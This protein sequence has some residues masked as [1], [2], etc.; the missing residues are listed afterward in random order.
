MDQAAARGLREQSVH[1]FNHFKK[2]IA[3]D[4][5]SNKPIYGNLTLLAEATSQKRSS[6]PMVTETLYGIEGLMS[7]L[8][9]MITL[10]IDLGL[11]EISKNL[12]LMCKEQADLMDKILLETRSSLWLYVF[13]LN[14]IYNVLKHQHM[15]KQIYANKSY[16]LAQMVKQLT[17][18]NEKTAK[19]ETILQMLEELYPDETGGGG[20]QR[21]HRSVVQCE[22]QKDSNNKQQKSA[23]GEDGAAGVIK[24][25]TAQQK[26]LML[27]TEIQMA[28]ELVDNNPQLSKEDK[29]YRKA[30]LMKA[31]HRQQ[32]DSG[33]GGGMAGT[34]SHLSAKYGTAGGFVETIFAP[35]IGFIE[36]VSAKKLERWIRELKVELVRAKEH[37]LS[38][39]ERAY[40]E[41]ERIK[42]SME[43]QI[44]QRKLA[45]SNYAARVI[46]N[47]MRGILFNRRVY[48][49][50]L[51]VRATR[52][53]RVWVKYN[54]IRKM[55]W[56]VR[57]IVLQNW[58]AR[59]ITR[60]MRD[61]VTLLRLRLRSACIIR[62]RMRS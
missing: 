42:K 46:Q 32:Q 3:R 29:E 1:L 44:E 11:R 59:V 45:R 41:M 18:I 56:G 38:D 20:G 28:L 52:I 9:M 7:K 31:R 55:R 17:T 33:A 19:D 62:Q 4:N 61:Y 15:E 25:L 16:Q 22:Q 54:I 14:S 21:S 13:S 53:Q 47:R 58:A 24:K 37:E 30:E 50:F 27:D 12:R 6:V 48:R 39:A 35:G 8:Q 5:A 10:H 60:Y 26:Q 23:A 51:R 2:E 49:R 34:E 43:E 57:H 40:I 36:R